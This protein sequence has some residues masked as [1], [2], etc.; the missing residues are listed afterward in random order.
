MYSALQECDRASNTL[1]TLKSYYSMWDKKILFLLN[2]I[3]VCLHLIHMCLSSSNS[4]SPHRSISTY[5]LFSFSFLSLCLS[6][7]LLFFKHISQIVFWCTFWRS[8]PHLTNLTIFFYSRYAVSEILLQSVTI[9]L[10]VVMERQNRQNHILLLEHA[11]HSI[12]KLICG[13]V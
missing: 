1:I 12:I 9:F 3:S 7:S 10:S 5:I 4:S 6:F 11:L 13:I 2:F 8:F